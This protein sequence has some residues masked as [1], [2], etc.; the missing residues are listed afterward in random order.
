MS[1]ADQVLRWVLHHSKTAGAAEDHVL[2]LVYDHPALAEPSPSANL[3]GQTWRIRKVTGELTLRDAL[4]E[5]G[6]LVAIVPQSFVVPMDLAGRAWL[7]RPARVRPRDLVSALTHRPCEPIGDEALARA[8]EAS[9]PRLQEMSGGW[10]VGGPVTVREIRNVLLGLQLGGGHRLDR[11]APERQLAH[12]IVDGAPD[13]TSAGLL[14]EALRQ[15]HGKVGDW[16]AWSLTDGSL[17][18]LVAA[19]ALAGTPEGIAV[20]PLIS[21]GLS[22]S[23]RHRLRSMVEQAVRLAWEQNPTLAR[24]S[25]EEAERRSTSLD[26]LLAPF[27]PLLSGLL[28]RYLG[29]AAKRAAAGSPEDDSRLEALS[30]NLHLSDR[31]AA[32]EPVRELSRLARFVAV[33]KVPHAPTLEV[34]ASMARQD[35]A[36]AD[37]AFRRARRGLQGNVGPRIA[38]AAKLMLQQVATRRDELNTA[39]AHWLAEHWSGVAGQT[40]VRQTFALH[41]L[42]RLVLLPLLKRGERVLLVVLDGCDLASFVDLM[43]QSDADHQVVLGLP[44]VTDPDAWEDLKAGGAWRVAMAPVPTVTSHARRALFAGDIPR[45]SALDA[46]EE[47]AANASHDK[48]AFQANPALGEHGR[49]LFLKGDVGDLGESVREALAGSDPLVAVVL[50]DVD[51]S[52][53]S[54]ET[55]PMGPW[56]LELL[57]R[58][59]AGWLQEALDAGWVVLV[60]ADHGHTPYV[61]SD[62]KL[63]AAGVGSRIASEP[64]PGVVTITDGPL[65]DSPLHLLTGFGTWRSVQRR[66]WHGGASLEEVFVPLAFLQRGAVHAEAFRPPVWWARHDARDVDQLEPVTALPDE[67]ADALRL[68]PQGLELVRSVFAAEVVPLDEVARQMRQPEKDVRQ[69]AQ[70]VGDFLDRSDVPGTVVVEDAGLRWSTTPKPKSWL[71]R[72]E[73]ETD[74]EVLRYLER[75]GAITE[76]ELVELVGNARRVRR[77]ANRVDELGVLAPFRIVVDV[78]PDGSRR[79]GAVRE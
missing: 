13:V 35:I 67:I 18:A 41:H 62:R 42:S 33:T 53:S 76:R 6:R 58:Q 49:T 74:R 7:G 61:G 72:I 71:D 2:V 14:T 38:A 24:R 16:L 66:G 11:E 56:R 79:F 50:N 10:S 44:T 15:E 60:T 47:V 29:E 23:D 21:S 43:S 65:P 34:W 26:A 8:V 69:L 59:A 17:E 4:L 73:D 19:G 45:S 27:H 64:G 1:F 63:G 55:T 32:Y 70:M 75:H 25:L 54:K 40:D 36:W 46:T 39:F 30:T 20:S 57:G 77:F 12:W 48:K 22:V 9:L 5:A 28:D 31:L 78:L 51:D 3:V 52:L 37:L 68:F